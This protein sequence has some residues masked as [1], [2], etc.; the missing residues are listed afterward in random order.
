M[1]GKYHTGNDNKFGDQVKTTFM[2]L[3]SPRI[4]AMIRNHCSLNIGIPFIILRSS[5]TVV[6]KNGA[7]LMEVSFCTIA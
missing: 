4:K 2:V 5:F 3:L 7:P 1:K 6:L